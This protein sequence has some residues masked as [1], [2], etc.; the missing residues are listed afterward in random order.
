MTEQTLTAWLGKKTKDPAQY[1]DLIRRLEDKT[2]WKSGLFDMTYNE[3]VMD[4]TRDAET[5]TA[6]VLFG[7]NQWSSVGGGVQYGWRLS[8]FPPEGK[9]E[10]LREEVWR[11]GHDPRK[12]RPHLN[13]NTISDVKRE[14]E[15]W[16]VRLEFGAG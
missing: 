13:Y 3:W 14:G 10:T 15:R 9:S 7:Q 2:S 12:D 1:A 16:C 8:A 5:G 6:F 11:H 4:V